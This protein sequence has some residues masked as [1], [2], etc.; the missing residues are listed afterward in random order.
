MADAVPGCDWVSGEEGD[1]SNGDDEEG[2]KVHKPSPSE[3]VV[4]AVED[5]VAHG[6]GVVERIVEIGVFRVPEI[7]NCIRSWR[8][9]LLRCD[10]C[11]GP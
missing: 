8:W 1:E 11:G 10:W 5:G 3:D 9:W 2:A 4:A 7:P 6:V